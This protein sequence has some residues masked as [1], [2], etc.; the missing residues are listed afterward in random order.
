MNKKEKLELAGWAVKKALKSGANNVA[1]D[2]SNSRD[3]DIEFRDGQLDR[4]KEST[5]NSLSLSI[6]ADNKYSSHST[7]DIRKD[8]LEKFIGEAV[9]MTKYLNEDPFRTLPDPEYY[10]NRKNIDL[11]FYDPTYESV[12]SKRRVEIAREIEDIARA[13]SDKVITCTAYYSD[14]TYESVKVHSN[15]FEGSRRGT[16]FSSG[17]EATVEDANGGRPSDWEW[18]SVRRFDDLLSSEFLGKSA[19]ERALSKVGQKKMESGVYDA[20]VDKRAGSRIISAL[21]GAMQ[22]RS[23]QQKRSFLE[24]KIGEKIASERLTINDDPFIVG[25]LGSRLYDGEGM[26]TKKRVM[27]EKGI[28]K[29]F[30][31]DWYYSRKLDMKPTIGS[32]TNLTLEYGNRSRDEM[33]KDM[34]KG[35]LITSFIGG[36]SNST[37]GDFSVGIVGQYVEN[38]QIVKPVN[39]MNITA[40]ITDLLN[41]LVEVGNDP[42]IYSSWRLPSLYFKDIQFSGI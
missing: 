35:I 29:D 1:V 5:Q 20:L 7:N 34:K 32:T 42:R 26:T 38:G 36:N 8:G 41:Q 25:G 9:A 12:D 16:S 6:Y 23:L 27:L 40:N 11:K 3:I 22:G 14:S 10:G 24:G 13:T 17:V 2:I 37:T 21:Y 39:E 19:V 28:L 4:L 31:I 18:A 30:Y 33:L 15:G